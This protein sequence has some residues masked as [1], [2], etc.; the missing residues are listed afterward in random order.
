MDA[1]ALD[2]LLDRL[3]ARDQTGGPVVVPPDGSVLG[4]VGA[5]LAAFWYGDFEACGEAAAR[6]TARGSDDLEVVL[7]QAATGL[8]VAGGAA[9]LE[10]RAW[11]VDRALGLPSGRLEDFARHLTA[12]SALACGRL[13]V[14]T[15]M[16]DASPPWHTS[17]SGHPYEVMMLAS[18]VRTDAFAARIDTAA[19]LV[20]ELTRLGEA[21]GLGGITVA[22]E[23]LVTGNADRPDETARAV[24]RLLAE[25]L[26]PIDRVGRGAYLLAAFGAVATGDVHGASALILVA[27]G[28]DLAQ[29]PVIDRSIGLEVLV[30]AAEVDGDLDAARA[31]LEQATPI[32]DH[33]N[34]RPALDRAASRVAAMEGDAT[35]AVELAERA[36]LAARA[37]GRVIEAAEGEV[38]LARARLA[39][40]DHGRAAPSLRA[41]VAESDA[42][43][44]HAMRRA[45]ADVLRRVGRRLPPVAAGGWDVL[46]PRE[47]EVAELI[48]TGRE[49]REIAAL[50]FLS[51]AT[52]RVH[53]SRVLAAFAVGSRVALLAR[54]G[55]RGEPQVPVPALTPRQSE[56][57]A[58]L[59]TGSSNAEIATALGLS[60][61]G[62]EK[63][64]GDALARWGA[65]SRF[66]LALRWWRD[67]PGR[68]PAASGPITR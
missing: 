23:S 15:A 62:V 47:V 51:P 4:D 32:A 27:G 41:A 55:A 12:E 13:D 7:A 50:L 49:Q 67:G 38:V 34:A 28:Q 54:L 9:A 11:D 1:G 17:W 39:A 45:A 60:V 6:A 18:T 44:H 33:P 24:S 35:R 37:E 58:L 8:A 66:D 57:A 16:V 64:V 14:A 29:L 56:V 40:G 30:A 43:G 42:T 20:P 63:H 26:P 48:L 10:L 65:G 61:K 53:T 22:V 59:A 31:W 68:D 36:V 21:H 2:D 46:S 5:A 3:V 25:E 19:A 52:V